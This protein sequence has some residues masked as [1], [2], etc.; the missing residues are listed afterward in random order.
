M[1]G[2]D[3]GGLSG[4][5]AVE[6]VE[7]L[8][9][10]E[11]VCAAA[12]AQAA[13]RA[14][15]C[16]A[17]RARGHRSGAEWLGK[18]MGTSRG[19]AATTIETARAV[20]GLAATKEAFAAGRLSEAQAAE[21]A[22]AVAVDPSAED[23]LLQVAERADL[24][25]LKDQARRVRLNAESR[26]ALHA[27]QHRA[28]EFS[29]WIDDEGMVA[30]RFR[31]PPEVGTPLVNRI[32]ARTDR[33]Y[34]Q[35]WRQG[36]R[37]PRAAYAADAL[38]ELLS[39]HTSGSPSRA[40]VVVVV[41]LHALRRGY[42]EDGER[43]HIPGVGPMPVAVARRIASDAFLK[44]VLVDGCEISKVKHFGR[45]IP[46][47]VRTALELGPAPDL[48]G[49]CCVEEGCGRRHGLEWDHVEPLAHH[50]PT[51]YL[52]LKPR[53]RPHHR[54]KTQRDRQAGLLPGPDPP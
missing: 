8:A 50:G 21:V 18:T 31:L 1:V 13:A 20:E 49:A 41:D 4:S 24:R 19:Q 6:L 48:D 17:W 38:V 34:K 26:E 54:D 23:G 39:G 30:G 9:Q 43:C 36:H 22:K 14:E 29:H 53:C 10:V 35:G 28:R 40:D 32:D 46:A 45:H 15:D 7:T 44:G 16:G 11:K 2:F 33:H 12:R 5:Q 42:P 47:E 25:S 27:R 51:A 37:E 3:P 52:N